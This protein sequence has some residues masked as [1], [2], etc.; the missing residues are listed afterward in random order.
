MDRTTFRADATQRPRSATPTARD[1]LLWLAVATA[2]LGSASGYTATVIGLDG[3]GPGSLSLLRFLFAS[4]AL[5][6][7]AIVGAVRRPRPRDL[8]IILLAGFLAFSVFSVALA[9]GQLTVPVGTASLIIAIIP[10]CTTLLARVFLGE[11]PGVLGWLGV[12]ASF[13]GVAVITLGQD[14]GFGLATGT[15]WVIL[16]TGSASAY[17]VL[18][19]GPLQRY[20]AIEFT[21]YAI[22]A[23]TLFLLPFAPQLAADVTGA[24]LSATLAAAWLGLVATVLA[25]GCIAFAFARLPASR[26]VSLESLIPP[27]AMLIAFVRLGEEPSATSLL[28]GVIAI[29]G[30]LVVNAAHAEPRG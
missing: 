14:A 17:F 28:G 20:R 2:I 23:G 7:G 6:G 29:V 8:P 11:R 18:Q 12:A 4:I 26:A 21:A 19:K 24:T 16:A 22:W 9:Q 25:Y 3:Y 13:V 27:A 10:A 15:P 30:V 5:A 1:P